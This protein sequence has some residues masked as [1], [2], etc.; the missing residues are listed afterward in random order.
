MAK[1]ALGGA[2]RAVVAH[3]VSADTNGGAAPMREWEFGEKEAK[4]R[5][6]LPWPSQ[7]VSEAATRDSGTPFLH[8][9]FDSASGA[10][11]GPALPKKEEKGGKSERQDATGGEKEQKRSR[12]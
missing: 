3:G 9:E 7:A 11:V 4:L 10:A 1:M 8:I 6:S 5:L 12:K 2:A